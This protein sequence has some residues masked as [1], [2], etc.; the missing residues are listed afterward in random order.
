M[1]KEP[2]HA[3]TGLTHNGHGFTTSADL[4]SL[5]TLP[6]LGVKIG[7]IT[8]QCPKKNASSKTNHSYNGCV[9][10]CG[11]PF[12]PEVFAKRL[13]DIRNWPIFREP[14][15][16][17]FCA[18]HRSYRARNELEGSGYKRQKRC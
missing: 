13:A 9:Q 5:K 3:G 17:S 8:S 16:E 7:K 1:N 6:F 4:L 18:T 11:L 15:Q 10:F 12:G 2:H 14:L